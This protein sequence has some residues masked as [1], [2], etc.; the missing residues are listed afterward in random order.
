MRTLTIK[1]TDETAKKLAHHANENGKSPEEWAA[2]V[3]EH[4]YDESWL[5]DLSPEDR[6]AIEEGLAEADRGETIPHEQ[7]VA[8]MKTK[9]GW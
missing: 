7:V 4:A 5:D 3:V 9:F 1:L 8:E 6:T 2:R